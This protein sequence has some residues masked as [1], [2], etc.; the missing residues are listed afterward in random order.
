LGKG[1]S[2]G[3]LP[4]CGSLYVVEFKAGRNDLFYIGENSGVSLKI[5]DLVIVEADRGKDLGKITNDSITPQQIQAMQAQQAEIA[6]LQAHQ[7][8]SGG[9]SG[10]SNNNGTGG[11]RAPKEI[12][13]KRIFR[14]AQ[15]SEISQLVNK[16]QDEVKAMMV[17]QTKVR[18][19][20]LPMEVVDA[21]YQW[22]RRKLTFY[23]IAERRI[24]FRELVRDLFKIYKTRIWMFA[25]NP[26]M[27]QSSTMGL[28]SQTSSPPPMSPGPVHQQQH[29]QLHQHS[30][31]PPAVNSPT[32]P[33]L[34][35]IDRQPSPMNPMNSYHFSQLSQQY[36]PQHAQYSQYPQ[37][38]QVPLHFQQ[39]HQQHQ[40]HQQQLVAA[41][42]RA[43]QSFYGLQSSSLPPLSSPSHPHQSH[44]YPYPSLNP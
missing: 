9:G 35:H 6:A 16:N 30:Q 12:H 33:R 41:H 3:Q 14:L 42:H 38:P 34:P 21:E 32:S 26:S 22:D 39:Q 29:Q 8:G 7:D 24:D 31:G 36:Q 28:P 1:L 11:H 10:S 25:V 5:G 13:P 2:L 27:V 37:Y 20:R 15:S 40:Q 4:N 18:Q 44:S 23:F 43:P 19:K 17:C